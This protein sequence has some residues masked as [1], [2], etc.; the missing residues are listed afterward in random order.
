MVSDFEL[1]VFCSCRAGDGGADDSFAGGFAQLHGVCP[2]EA[3]LFLAEGLE[4][5]SIRFHFS[6]KKAVEIAWGERL[7]YGARD[8]DRAFF[9]STIA[10]AL[11]R[12]Q[13]PARK[14]I[15]RAVVLTFV[16]SVPLIPSYLLVRTLHMDNT[17][18]ALMIPGALGAFNIIIMKTFFQGLS[19]E[20]FD[21]AQMDGCSEYGIFARIAIPLSMPVIATIALFHAVGQW[22]SYFSAL[23]YIRSK[24]MYL[25]QVLLRNMVME[26][27]VQDSMSASEMASSFTPE[28]MKAGVVLFATLPILVVYPLLQ[29]HFVKGAMLGS[30]KE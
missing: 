16:F 5:R 17:L 6:T 27:Q 28:Q 9:T 1:Y 13:M 4:F 26:G 7:Y 18:W 2:C 11:S 10:Y 20:L 23:I 3:G 25:L 29:R 15:L 21:A 22:N 30:L 24:D 8:H 19:A 12:P 14:L